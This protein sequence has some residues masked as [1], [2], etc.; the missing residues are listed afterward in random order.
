MIQDPVRVKLED[1]SRV[2][3]TK[4]YA[5]SMG[6]TVLKDEKATDARGDARDPQPA[7]SV[8]GNVK[9]TSARKSAAKKTASAP[10]ASDQ[11]ESS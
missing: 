5:E 6:L 11:E 1:G 9:K 10:P 2:T 7:D 8:S 4:A 3:V